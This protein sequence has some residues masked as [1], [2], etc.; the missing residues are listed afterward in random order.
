MNCGWFEAFEWLSVDN[1][2]VFLGL[3]E[4]YLGCFDSFWF[5]SGSLFIRIRIPDPGKLYGSGGSGSAP[6]VF[7]KS[8]SQCSILFPFLGE[9]LSFYQNIQ[10]YRYLVS[11]CVLFIN[12]TAIVN[13]SLIETINN[14]SFIVTSTLRWL[15]RAAESPSMTREVAV[16]DTTG[17]KYDHVLNQCLRSVLVC[18]RSRSSLFL[19]PDWGK[20]VY[21]TAE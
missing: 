11:F 15:V 13:Q 19:Y 5:G 7:R 9:R 12:Y 18:N 2:S 21:F 10:T 8:F 6:L 16:E 17:E 14:S 1:L 20:N 4:G 3:Y